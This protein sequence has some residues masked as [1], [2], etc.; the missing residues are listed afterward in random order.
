MDDS[1]DP[2]DRLWPAFDTRDPLITTDETD[3]WPTGSLEWLVRLKLLV[4]A[5]CASHVTC[6]ACCDRHDEEVTARREPNGKIRYFISCPEALR[7]EIAPEMRRQW[8][9]DFSRLAR[10]LKEQL[11][12]DGRVRDRVPDRLWRLGVVPW[13]RSEVREVYLARGLAAVDGHDVAKP[14]ACEGRP[15]VF[16]GL[17]TP[18]PSL[19]PAISPAVVPLPVVLH[20]E[21]GELRLDR[22]LLAQFVNGA[23]RNAEILGSIHQSE[24]ERRVNHIAERRMAQGSADDLITAL[25]SQGL[26]YREIE[27]ELSK[28]GM[29]MDHST[30]ARR[31]KP[32]VT[33]VPHSSSSV[34]RHASSQP[35]DKRRKPIPNAQPKQEE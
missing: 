15:I 30:I 22:H 34:V 6:P 11:G 7:V 26:S 33:R 35:R 16:V 17:V 8:R 9:P 13:A 5:E 12:I 27:E 25:V 14:I 23:D 20:T 28:R 21:G 18:P 31:K 24:L 19:W 4:P 10:K 29:R 2:L 3:R 32:L 1:P